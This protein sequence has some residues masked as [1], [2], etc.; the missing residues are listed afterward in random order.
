M[1]FPRSPLVLNFTDKEAGRTV[2]LG[3]KL[4]TALTMC[5]WRVVAHIRRQAF[6]I[7][8]PHLH[9]FGILRYALR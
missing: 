2:A 5:E 1:Q 8:N 6:E 9:K 3:Q 7:A 4:R